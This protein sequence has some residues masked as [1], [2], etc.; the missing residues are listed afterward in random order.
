MRRTTSGI[1]GSL[2]SLALIA[3]PLAACSAK[4]EAAT[5]GGAQTTT[6]TTTEGTTPQEYAKEEL[7]SKYDM[8]EKGLVTPVKRQNPWGTCWAFG[9]TAAVESSILSATDSTYD[10]IGLDLSEKHLAYFGLS[11]ITEDEDPEQAGEGIHMLDENAKPNDIYNSGGNPVFAS[12]LLST[13]VYGFFI[14]TDMFTMFMFYEVALIPMYLL[15]GVW[16][17]GNK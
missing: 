15:I 8:R 17:S 5:D 3:A 12:T 14:C 1:V 10:E 6:T 2:L 4:Q 7:P 16:G 9:V 13:G 11:P